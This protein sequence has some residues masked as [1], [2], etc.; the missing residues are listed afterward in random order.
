VLETTINAYNATTLW[1]RTYTSQVYLS[2]AHTVVIKNISPS[3]SYVDV[4]AIRIITPVDATDTTAP[5]AITD[6]AAGSGTSTGT[7]DLSWTAPGDD[8]GTPPTGTATSYLVR[9]STEPIDASNWAS[10]TPASGT[11]PTPSVYNTPDEHMTVTGLIPGTTYYFGVRAQDEVTNLGGMSNSPSI[12]AKDFTASVGAG[13]YDDAD[14]SW[15]YGNSWTLSG[16]LHTTS[17]LNDV[18]AFAFTGP[19]KFILSYSKGSSRGSF[20]IYVDDTLVTTISAYSAT[21]VAGQYTG[22]CKCATGTHLLVIKNIGSSAGVDAIQIVEPPTPDGTVYDDGHALW[23]Y[24]GTWTAA[25]G[26]TGPHANTLH[27][28]STPNDTAEFSFTGAA[29]FTLSY[30]KGSNRASFQVYVDDVLV[31]TINAYDTATSYATFTS[32]VSG[33]DAHTVTIKHDGPNNSAS[34]T[35]VDVDAIQI[36]P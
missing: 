31:D 4:D 30:S 35:Y 8:D 14:G 34:G 22:P 36:S 26:I 28:T 5:S 32:S 12:E 7:V 23:T 6:L 18:A 25:T 2:G 11:I 1:K 20:E 19:A 21:V 27:Y 10:A 15:Y 13:T 17:T 9:Y 33:T 29:S 24:T 16:A 3:G